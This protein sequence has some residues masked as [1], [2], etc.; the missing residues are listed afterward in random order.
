MEHHATDRD[1][2]VGRPAPGAAPVFTPELYVRDLEAS[3]RQ[4]DA[5]LD[6]V[7][8]AASRF[9][10]SADWERDVQEV[11]ARLGGATEV[12]RVYLFEAFRDAQ[13]V[14]RASMHHEW[15]LPGVRPRLNDP[16]VQNLALREAGLVS[17]PELEQ[18]KMIH[19]PVRSLLPSE[20]EYFTRIGIRS[21]AVVP[22]FAGEAWWGFLGFTDDAADREW[23]PVVL[24]VLRAAASALGAALF[25]KRAEQEVRESE[26][27][28]RRLTEA[29]VEAVFIH[30]EGIVLDA[31][32]ALARMF[33]YALDEL[34]GR[35]I[36]DLLATPESREV[37]LQH[38]RADSEERYEA[39]GRHKDG[40]LVFCEITART[41][42][43]KGQ[44]ARVATL[45]DI[46][47]RKCTEQELRRRETQ[48][49][50]AQRIAHL[51]SWE[52]DIANNTERWSDELFRLYGVEPRPTGI[53]PE[54]FLDRV[55]PDDVARVR[56]EFEGALRRGDA[57]RSEHR[58][59]RPDGTVRIVRDEAQIIADASGKPVRM[60]G[61]VQD[62]TEQKQAEERERQL[63]R[64]RAAR[65]A[66]ERERQRSAFLAESSRVLASS[67]DYRTALAALARLAVPTLADMCV[68]DLVGDERKLERVGFAHVDPAKEPDLRDAVRFAR[69]ELERMYHLHRGLVEADSE[70]I[71]EIDDAML[72]A[73]AG[74]DEQWQC[75]R[76][77]RPRSMI[78]VPLRVSRKIIGV[79]SLCSAESGRHFGPDDLALAEELAR[80]AGSAIE[81]AQLYHAAQQATRARDEILAVVAHDLR[82]PLGTITMAVQLLSDVPP[83]ARTSTGSRPVEIIRRSAARMDRLIQDLLEIRRIEAGQLAIEARPVSVPTVVEEAAEMLK[84][85]ADAQSIALH[86]ELPDT[87]PRIMADPARI[88]QV[89]SNLVGNA[90]KF[91]PVGGRIRISASRIEREVCLKVQDTGPGIP[92]DQLPHI[93]GR[94]WQAKRGDRR[95][96]GL[97]LAIAKGLVEA[98]GGR[99]WAESPPGEGSSFF[100]TVPVAA[101]QT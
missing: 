80:R 67:F 97:G 100:F 34:I 19:G 45:H 14:L 90:L 3:I 20:R 53:T 39:T 72:R 66:A 88:Q 49:A 98:H 82:N 48:L 99:I 28:F 86:V 36:I 43:Y 51:G 55:H 2:P 11:L 8:Y 35:N 59:V 71:P 78:T 46:T 27:R 74:G 1:L 17:W 57:P 9:L 40:S 23:S 50:E 15:T 89:L 4:R 85:L 5:V 62:I 76:T 30:R 12:S 25:R 75:L 92:A 101:E 79:L 63:I 6:A 10:G 96:L 41:T 77:L 47:E 7:C 95:G 26:E 22:V 29:S 16:D 93:F 21:I 18:G 69:G 87:M 52:W 91:T 37:I 68:V 42:M 70:M 56:E 54:M 65:A 58:V 32:P 31:N 38:M 84:P 81:N 24:E 61:I 60:V 73:W 94:F 33:G 64:E 83:G 13:G 44:P